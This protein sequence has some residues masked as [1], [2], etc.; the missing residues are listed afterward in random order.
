[1]VAKL[2]KLNEYARDDIM[3]QID[4]LLLKAKQ[5]RLQY[6]HEVPLSIRLPQKQFSAFSP[7]AHVYPNP[8]T[9]NSSSIVQY[10]F[11][12]PS[13]CN[14]VSSIPNQFSQP[15]S[16]FNQTQSSLS[17]VTTSSTFAE[18]R[19]DPS[20]SSELLNTVKNYFETFNDVNQ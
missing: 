8:S 20:S 15:P 5:G 12:P 3:L 16:P 18:T 1:M 13:S 11:S 2:R 9:S 7:S 19:L 4:H 6:Q 14:S 17:Q 10:P